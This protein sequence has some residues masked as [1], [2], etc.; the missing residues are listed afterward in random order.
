[1]SV[2]VEKLDEGMA[3]LTVEVSEETL[4]K[5][6]DQAYLKNKSRINVPGFRKGK[7][8]RRVIEQIYGKGIFYDDAANEVIYEE[9]PKAV[10]ES[11]E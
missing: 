5:A 9:Y 6:I 3:K 11:K 4:K 8:P 7:A 2:K 1:M 10:E